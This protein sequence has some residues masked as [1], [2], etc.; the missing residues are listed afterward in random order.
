MRFYAQGAG[1]G[2]YFT[3]DKAVLSFA[4]GE[5]RPGA[6]ASLPRRQP[7]RELEAG[8]RRARQ[9]QL[10]GRRRRRWHT[11]LPTYGELIYRELWPGIDMVFRGRGGK[12]KY[13]FH[14]SPGARR[15]RHP[16]RLP[17][18][19]R[20]LAW[21]GRSLLIETPLGTLR[22]ARPRSYQRSTA[23]ACRSQ[24]RYVA[25][26]GAAATASRVGALRPAAPLVIDPGLVYSTYLGGSGIDSGCGVAVD[27]AGSAYVTG[28]PARPTSR[29]PPA[30]STRPS[31]A[32]S[33]AFVTKL[34][35]AGSALVYSTY[36]GG[37]GSDEGDGDRGRRARAAPT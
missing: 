19:E 11:N 10:P 5:A 4:K 20:P 30:P 13:E 21:R 15:R 12:L 29:P 22:D 3:E 26:G 27:A 32:A 36:L 14:V 34:N 9:G 18:R 23:G 16:A 2:F 8:R 1:F 6:R 25:R 7:E 24:S 31:T 37:A 33:D 17:R 28:A 35:A